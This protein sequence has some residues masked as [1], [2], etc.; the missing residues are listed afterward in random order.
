VRKFRGATYQIEV[1]N[2]KKVSKGVVAV[3]VDGK[4]IAGNVLP[5]LPAGTVAEVVVELG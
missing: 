1:R 5:I 2:P 4:A 3:T